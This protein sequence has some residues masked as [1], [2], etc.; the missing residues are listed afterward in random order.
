MVAKI[1]TG[2]EIRG[3]ILYN[4]SKVQNRKA[5][6]IHGQGFL[7][8]I[9]KLSDIEK[10]AR[11]QKRF[12]LNK[13]VKTNTLHIS[14]NFSRKDQLDDGL[15]SFIAKDY[16]DR[17]GF[18]KQPYLV[19]RHD[20]TDH[21]HIHIVSTNID[22][23]GKRLETHNLGKGVSEIARREI[24][25][26][27]GLVRAES[28]Q[29]EFLIFKPLEKLAYGK[30]ETKSLIYNIVTEVL[31]SYHFE[32]FPEFKAAL[33]QF[34]VS[35]SKVNA[36]GKEFHGNGLVYS[37][38]DK[39]GKPVSVPI[40]SSSLY[41]KPTY[42][43]ILKKASFNKGKINVDKQKAKEDLMLRIMEVQKSMALEAAGKGMLDLF[44][45]G[46][47]RKGIYLH[48]VYN[49][50]GRLYGC[51]YVDNIARKVY[52]GSDLGKALGA[53]GITKAFGL[54]ANGNYPK[55][56]VAQQKPMDGESGRLSDKDFPEKA[57]H[58]TADATLKPYGLS[59]LVGFFREILTPDYG[60]TQ[61]ND[62]GNL[63]KKRKKK[64]KG[65]Q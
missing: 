55:G 23:N 30:G 53:N 39:N 17:I 60:V 19:Y 13:R 49:K 61:G 20:D 2:K 5:V 31:R 65:R 21:P 63:K 47:S 43:K 54:T 22:Q 10:L 6:L 33:A 56:P 46:L 34:N 28:Q 4:E 32:S 41:G 26:S 57:L 7:G 37:I 40:K 62:P 42:P 25:L 48:L 11:F 45:E 24:E 3:L 15:L 44:L 51:T 12:G 35:A 8:N 16:M 14:L 50:N 27:L 59:A 9:Q 18:G 52:K 1:T 36:T 64:R 58:D 38:I 29:K